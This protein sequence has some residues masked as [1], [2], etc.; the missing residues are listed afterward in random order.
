MSTRHERLNNKTLNEQHSRI[1][2][3]LM[4]RADNRKCVDCRKKG[5]FFLLFTFLFILFFSY[6]DGNNPLFL[7]LELGQTRDGPRGILAYLCASAALVK[8]ADLDAWTPEQ[9]ANMVKWGN[10]KANAYWEASLPADFQGPPESGIDQ[11]IRDKYEG[12]RFTA[13]GPIPDPDTIP[14]PDGILPA[15]ST[16]S[17]APSQ[18]I[19]VPSF[20]KFPKDYQPEQIQPQQISSGKTSTSQDLLDIFQSPSVSASANATSIVQKQQADLK[21]N[22]MSLYSTPPVQQSTIPPAQFTIPQQQQQQQHQLAGLQFFSSS[23]IQSQPQFASFASFSTNAT[24]SPP[25]Q[26]TSGQHLGSSPLQPAFGSALLPGVAKPAIGGIPDFMGL[27]SSNSV[28][29]FGK[30]V[31]TSDKDVWGEFQ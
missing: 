20:S 18:T 24:A 25:A 7:I 8:S 12:K 26:A 28:N 29:T 14:F 16:P 15:S 2:K 17:P 27:G 21:S 23:N 1:L 31:S 10:A 22:I 4:Q 9:I 3:N 19:P 11:W 6:R 13:G 30:T 5:R